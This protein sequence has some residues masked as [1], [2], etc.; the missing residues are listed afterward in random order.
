MKIP[1]RS[2]PASS[3]VASRR[4]GGW[5][6]GGAVTVRPVLAADGLYA[7]SPE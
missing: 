1:R 3:H 4:R 6:D 5:G 7:E 2:R